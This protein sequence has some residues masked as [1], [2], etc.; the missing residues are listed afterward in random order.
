MNPQSYPMRLL[1]LLVSSLNLI[2]FQKMSKQSKLEIQVETIIVQYPNPELRK[3][4]GADLPLIHPKPNLDLTRLS[5]SPALVCLKITSSKQY[6]IGFKLDLF[7]VIGSHSSFILFCQ[8]ATPRL[9]SEHIKRHRGTKATAILISYCT[10]DAR[11][12]LI[13]Q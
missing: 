12:E 11:M 10:S 9:S 13:C 5:K 6:T 7:R 2:P 3:S 4:I 8:K 1:S